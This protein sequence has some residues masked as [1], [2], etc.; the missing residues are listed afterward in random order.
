MN[1]EYFVNKLDTIKKANS[2]CQLNNIE[3]NGFLVHL[4]DREMLNLASDDYLG[5]STNPRLKQEFSEQVDIMSLSYSAASSRLFSGNHNYYKLL[6]DDLC[7]MYDKEASLVFNSAYHANIGILPAIATKHDLILVDKHVNV[8][9]IDGTRL[10]EATVLNYRHLDYDN[11]RNLLIQNRDKYSN[12]FIVSESIFG[13]DGDIVDLQELYEIKNE[14]DVVL[15]IDESYAVGVRGTNGLGCSEEQACITGI[16]FIVA[17]FGKAFASLGAFVV[18]DELYKEFLVNTQRSL[19]YTTA[20]PPI[21]I[22]WSRFIL[23]KMPE[24]YDL[25]IKLQNI[26]DRL[27]TVLMDNN[28]ETRGDSHIIPMIC[29]YNDYS[30]EISNLLQDNGFFVLPIRYPAVSK[31]DAR[32]KFSLNASISEEDYECLFECIDMLD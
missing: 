11:L 20:L 3:H 31:N 27:R 21:N 19:I 9:I 28:F 22:A 7:D 8:G 14:F 29:G 12:V 6:E 10:S 17:S 5:L 18:C 23:K 1:K 30:V 25:R 2:F 15:Y 26:S 24:F 32:V 4:D 13:L 16:D